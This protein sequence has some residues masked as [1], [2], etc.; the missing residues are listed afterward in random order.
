MAIT[1]DNILPLASLRIYDAGHG[2]PAVSDWG[3]RRYDVIEQC[4]RWGVYGLDAGGRPLLRVIPGIGLVCRERLVQKNTLLADWDTGEGTW[5][6]RKPLTGGTG[7]TFRL[8]QIETTADLQ[9]SATSKYHFAADPSFALSLLQRETPAD[10]DDSTY[11]PYVQWEWGAEWALRWDRDVGLSLLRQVDGEWQYAATFTDAG[12]D[13]LSERWYFVR[14][15]RGRILLSTDLGRTWTAYALPGG[16]ISVASA[17]VTI[18]GQ[19]RSIAFG[20]HQLQFSAGSWAAPKK[21]T[22][23]ARAAP[24]LPTIT[25]YGAEAHGSSV[26]TADG[27][28]PAVNPNLSGY[29]LT[30]T[31]GQALSWPWTM[32]YSPEVRAVRWRLATILGATGTDYETPFDGDL[33]TV[34]IEHPWELDE[35]SA[36]ITIE[37]DAAASFTGQYRRRKCVL[38]TGRLTSS[39]ATTTSAFVGYTGEAGCQQDAYNEAIVNILVENASVRFKRMLFNDVQGVA[40]LGGQTLNAL[41]DEWLDYA[42]LDTSYRSWHADGDLIVIPWGTDED[43]FCFPKVGER[44]WD[45]AEELC[46]RCGFELGIT[47][48]GLVSTVPIDYADASV[49]ATWYQEPSG[50]LDS[51]L[52]RVS[53]RYRA[54]ESYTGVMV[55]GYDANG[56]LI[57][58]GIIDVEALTNTASSRFCPWPEWYIETVHGACTT[59]MLTRMAIGLA[60]EK[61][62]PK[63]DASVR[64]RLNEEARVR[65]RHQINGAIVGT[66]DTDEYAVRTVTQHIEGDPSGEASSTEL[67]LRRL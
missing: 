10:H 57:L 38:L 41:L 19:G 22:W 65:Q 47:D 52:Q 5:E 36:R 17:K 20:M 26:A 15:Q 6:Q 50:E 55:R 66:S 45:W 39:G 2:D 14:Q 33:M 59:G 28:A 62:P 21:P 46:R 51:A 7:R 9:W 31:P 54:G 4:D 34:Q 27:S 42:G 40:P 12:G 60:L 64:V 37:H 25:T 63:F 1:D 44:L 23:V 49:I 58:S 35:A 48:A 29:T 67:E 13:P 11:P 53:L 61:I 30:L 24:L 3:H 56:A 16:A 43:P 32:Q 18:R 8:C